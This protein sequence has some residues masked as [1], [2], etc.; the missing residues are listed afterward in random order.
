MRKWRFT[1]HH[2][3]EKCIKTLSSQPFFIP[4]FSN[5]GFYS[6]CLNKRIF[7][8]VGVTT[9]LWLLL[10]FASSGSG[11]LLIP[12]TVS[13]KMVIATRSR[14]TAFEHLL[15][16]FNMGCQM[17]SIDLELLTTHIDLSLE[18][19]LF[20]SK[21]LV[22]V[23]NIILKNQGNEYFSLLFQKVL[24]WRKVAPFRRRCWF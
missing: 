3:H 24:Q 9:L 12:F 1:P 5:F 23:I 17:V 19:T 15:T 14:V 4:T 20:Y 7:V 22:T 8:T 13:L 6:W 10:F 21:C 2:Q 11:H 16:T 18:A